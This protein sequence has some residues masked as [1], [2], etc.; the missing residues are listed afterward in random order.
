M[1][2]DR[3]SYWTLSSPFR[4][5]WLSSELPGSTVS[6]HHYH[7][8]L[9]PFST[10]IT[11]IRCHTQLFKWMLSIKFQF[12]LYPLSHLPDPPPSFPWEI[13]HECLDLPPV[14]RK[15]GS[16]FTPSHFQPFGSCPL[17]TSKQ[18]RHPF[19]SQWMDLSIRPEKIMWWC[20][21]VKIYPWQIVHRHPHFRILKILN[22]MRIWWLWV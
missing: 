11:G 8:P 10:R 17:P 4:L 14:Q 12:S 3:V 9:T 7:H 20:F 19:I 6:A 5:D 15:L 13:A 2:W 22:K 18:G 16:T 21:H 1:I